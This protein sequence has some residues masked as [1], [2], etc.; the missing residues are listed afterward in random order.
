MQVLHLPQKSERPPLWNG[1]SYV[2]KYYGAEVIFNGMTSMLSFIKIYQ[3]VQMLLVW[4]TKTDG[5]VI[6]QAHL[7]S[8]RKN[9]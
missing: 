4:E 7:I 6:S 8:K 2:T 1:W 9:A 3:F 5:L